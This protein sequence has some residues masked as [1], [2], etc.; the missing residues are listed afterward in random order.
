MCVNHRHVPQFRR[1]GS[2]LHTVRHATGHSLPRTFTPSRNGDDVITTLIN[3][4]TP[5]PNPSRVQIQAR[6]AQEAP[7]SDLDLGIYDVDIRYDRGTVLSRLP[8][9]DLQ[10]ITASATKDAAKCAKSGWIFFAWALP[11]WVAGLVCLFFLGAPI[12]ATG[13]LCI[14]SLGAFAGV[15]KLARSNHNKVLMS[16]LHRMFPPPVAEHRA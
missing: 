11:T 6:L 10:S 9:N 5:L 2:D 8:G 16:E 3:T 7:V 1:A 4:G 14:G 15:R 13:A 12:A